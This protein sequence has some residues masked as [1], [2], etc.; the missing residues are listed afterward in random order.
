MSPVYSE[1]VRG[2]LFA[3][4]DTCTRS[5]ARVADGNLP[6]AINNVYIDLTTKIWSWGW[7][8]LKAGRE[9]R[10]YSGRLLFSC[11]S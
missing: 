2:N 10:T 1:T 5:G 8:Q 7:S 9:S 3:R 11:G 6:C 4:F